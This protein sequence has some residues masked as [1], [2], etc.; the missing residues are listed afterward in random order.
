[1]SRACKI[2]RISS[3]A[4]AVIFAAVFFAGRNFSNRKGAEVAKVSQ[5]KENHLK[6]MF[7][8]ALRVF[9]VEKQH[10]RFQIR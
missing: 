4:A 9:A 3:G 1:M 8:Y 5:R 6:P 2:G 7:I 10:Q